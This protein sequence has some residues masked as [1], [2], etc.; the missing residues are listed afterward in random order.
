VKS[1]FSIFPIF[2]TFPICV[3]LLQTRLSDPEFDE[4][5]EN[6]ILPDQ[7]PTI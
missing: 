1:A 4:N 2:A 3:I 7:N 5:H 6:M